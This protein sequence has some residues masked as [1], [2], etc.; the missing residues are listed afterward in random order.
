VLWQLVGVGS[1][2]KPGSVGQGGHHRQVMSNNVVHLSGDPRPLGG[3]GD[4]G[5][6]VAVAFQAFSA[7]A[8]R[9]EIGPAG[10]N[11]QTQHPRGHSHP[12][13]QNDHPPQGAPARPSHGGQHDAQ[14]EHPGTQHSP[15]QRLTGG[16]RV[17]PDKQRQI[18]THGLPADE[19]LHERDGRNETEDQRGPATSHQQR[20]DHGHRQEQL[21]RLTLRPAPESAGGSEQHHDEA[22]PK[23]GQPPIPAD[24]Q[25]PSPCGGRAVPGRDVSA[26]GPLAQ[27]ALGVTTT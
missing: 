6:L 11:V 2:R 5:L 10:A 1:Q 9:V 8:Q 4:E 20:Q 17:E 12:A 15:A 22:E 25:D 7:V 13:E 18:R 24:I 16:H 19:P 26:T 23:I 27:V 3:G 21:T 14:L